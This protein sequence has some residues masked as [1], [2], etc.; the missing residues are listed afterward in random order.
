MLKTITDG[1]TPRPARRRRPSRRSGT[2]RQKELN[3]WLAKATTWQKFVDFW[4]VD[5]DYGRRV[6][7]DG[8]P[9]FETD[10]QSFR[11]R[12]AKGEIEPLVFTAELATASSATT[13]SPRA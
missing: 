1:M 7:A 6:G 9:I 10:W 5:W 4:A 13:A 3:K 8:K 2:A 12:K 11:L